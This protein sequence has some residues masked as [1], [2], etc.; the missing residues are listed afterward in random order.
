LNTSL[1]NHRSIPSL[2]SDRNLY[3]SFAL[4]YQTKDGS[5]LFRRM[6]AVDWNINCYLLRLYYGIFSALIILFHNLNAICNANTKKAKR[7]EN[8]FM[9]EDLL[10]P[11]GKSH[12]NGIVET[13]LH[14]SLATIA[15]TMLFILFAK[16]LTNN[17]ESKTVLRKLSPHFLQHHAV[18]S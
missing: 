8:I 5:E 17:D 3:F 11:S 6:G 13:L 7:E 16:S 10:P 18:E 2:K 9:L 4:P 1:E 14:A 15:I 12:F